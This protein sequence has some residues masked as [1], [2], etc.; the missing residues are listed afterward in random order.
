MYTPNWLDV[1]FVIKKIRNTIPFTYAIGD[2]KGGGILE[3]FCQKDL[4]KISLEK[5]KIKKVIRK[6]HGSLSNGKSYD[7]SLNRRIHMKGIF[8]E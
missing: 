3:K 1:I 4:Q 6:K 8:Q 7:N 2:L 5:L